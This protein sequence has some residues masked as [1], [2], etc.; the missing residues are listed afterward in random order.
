RFCLSLFSVQFVR[1]VRVRLVADLVDRSLLQPPAVEAVR[2]GEKPPLAGAGRLL[3]VPPP[4]P[5][6]PR[7]RR[8]PP[9]PPPLPRP[10]RPRAPPPPARSARTAH[11]R[12][13]RASPSPRRSATTR[14]RPT[15]TPGTSRGR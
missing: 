7:V 5:P 9:P 10:P 3:R 2:G 1:A 11:S 8:P 12:P 14:G 15:G 4:P 6:P 13:R